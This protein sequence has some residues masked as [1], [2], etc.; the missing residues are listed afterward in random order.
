MLNKLNFVTKFF[1]C[2]VLVLNVSTFPNSVKNPNFCSKFGYNFETIENGTK[3]GS[4]RFMRCCQAVPTNSNI[5]LNHHYKKQNLQ[6]KFDN[7]VRHARVWGPLFY[8]EG[9]IIKLVLRCSESDV[10][11]RNITCLF[12]A[13]LSSLKQLVHIVCVS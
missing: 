10:E 12:F 1:K 11:L 2:Q 6:Q 9:I 4:W 13:L 8:R 5:I 3:V 7:T